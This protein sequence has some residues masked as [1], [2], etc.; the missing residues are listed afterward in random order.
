MISK[1]NVRSSFIA[2]ESSPAPQSPS[3]HNSIG[4]GNN[5][6]VQLWQFLLEILTD[7]EHTDIIEWVGTDGEFKLSDPDRV[8][9]LWGEKKNK[10]A[11]NYE[12]LSRALRYY[13]DGDMI[14]KV[15]GKRF[16]Y[17]FDCDL[18]LLIGYDACELSRLVN[19]RKWAEHLQMTQKDASNEG[20]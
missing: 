1:T 20:T 11:M 7:S 17:K 3:H 12:K 4:S 2:S 9:R 19:E 14:S 8:A 18:K 6:Q 5:G 15:S 10:P 13:Y 16:A